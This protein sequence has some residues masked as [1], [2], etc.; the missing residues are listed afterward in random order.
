MDFLRALHREIER[1]DIFNRAAALGFY[2]TLAVFPTMIFLMALIP[3]LPIA[4]VDRA[5]LDF[6][7]QTLPPR[8]A[9]LFTTIMH[10]V[11]NERR[12]G[13]L[14]AGLALALW[15]ASTGMYAIMQHTNIVFDVAEGRSFIRARATALA[16]MLLFAIL[17]LG[18][19]SLVV[20]GGVI[21]DSLAYRIGVS[22]G[23]F[24]F[25]IVFRWVVIVL[26]LVLAIALIYHFAPN[27]KRQFRFFTWGT[28]TATILLILASV[29]FRMYVANFADYGATYGSLAGV[30]ALML[31]LYLAG[32]VLLL[33][34]EIDSTA[35]QTF[36][37]RGRYSGEILSSSNK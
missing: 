1:H 11:L 21:Q 19:F 22:A 15:A 17:V 9:Q 32:L 28:A 27:R 16:L 12:G 8:T 5:I 37:V 6:I 34:A 35:A 36:A 26:A 13:M 4:H 3:Y 30:V 24:D 33:G 20:L 10:E 7:G 2:F 29:A 23:L 18:A 14:T 25:F 31:W